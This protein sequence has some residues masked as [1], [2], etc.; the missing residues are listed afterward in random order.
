MAEVEAGR[1]MHTIIFIAIIL[2]QQNVC[3]CLNPGC[4]L[5]GGAGGERVAT[6]GVTRGGSR[7]DADAVVRRRGVDGKAKIRRYH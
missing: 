7:G 6:C 4:W 5:A 2:G 3:E 1:V